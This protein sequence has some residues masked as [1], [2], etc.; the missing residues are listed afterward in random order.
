MSARIAWLGKRDQV[1]VI[2]ALRRGRSLSSC[3]RRIAADG[4]RDGL[5]NV[6]MEAASQKLAILSTGSLGDPGIH[7]PTVFT[8]DWYRRATHRALAIG[9]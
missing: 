3:P 5:P 9:T 8:V 6:L 2:A 1:E 7:R 4:D